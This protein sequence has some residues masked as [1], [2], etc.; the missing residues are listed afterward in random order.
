MYLA[1][2]SPEVL[3]VASGGDSRASI[4]SDI[5]Y[6]PRDTEN[7]PLDSVVEMQAFMV[8]LI[9]KFDISQADHHPQIKRAKT[10]AS[11]PLVLG[12]EYKGG[13][14]PLKITAIRNV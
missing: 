11:T 10:G 8:T 4:I 9:R 1:V 3:G 13:Q 2:R 5:I 7:Y 14:L 12:E 6:S